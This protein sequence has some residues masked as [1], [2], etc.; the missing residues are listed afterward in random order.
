VLAYGRCRILL[1][2]LTVKRCDHGG[3]TNTETRDEA[4][5]V[6]CGNLARCGGLHYGANDGQDSSQDEVV[7]ASDLVG[8]EPSA[9]SSDEAATL[10]S[11]DDVGLEIREWN[12]DQFCKAICS[13][14]L[15]ALGTEVCALHADLLFER[16][17][18]QNTSD[19]TGIHAEQ[20]PAEA[21]LGL[22]VCSSDLSRSFVHTE[23]AKAY[24]RHP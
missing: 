2:D 14:W 4:T 7:A 11:C 23:H 18:G 9:Q 22:S 5:N 6:D 15:S 20:H 8:D 17:H 19:D 13:E 10:E 16:G 21:C 3:G 24:T 1:G 12:I